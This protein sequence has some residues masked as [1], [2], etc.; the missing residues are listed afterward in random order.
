MTYEITVLDYTCPRK[1]CRAKVGDQCKNRPYW[2]HL[3]RYRKY[4]TKKGYSEDLRESFIKD[5]R[6]EET[7]P[8]GQETKA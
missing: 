2:Q 7:Y 6:R 8:N 4:L 5:I 1:D 3:M